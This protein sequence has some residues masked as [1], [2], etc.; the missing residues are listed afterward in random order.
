MVETL[1]VITV[2]AL[3]SFGKNYQA[4][5]FFLCHDAICFATICEIFLSNQYLLIKGL[6]A[7]ATK[8]ELSHNTESCSV[9]LTVAFL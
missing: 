7:I 3:I 2:S 1:C 4:S 9:E 6:L 5:I 8:T